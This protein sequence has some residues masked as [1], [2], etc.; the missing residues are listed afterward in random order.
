MKKEYFFILIITLLT[1]SIISEKSL[2][3]ELIFETYDFC[4]I[5]TTFYDKTKFYISFSHPKLISNESSNLQNINITDMILIHQ[6][7]LNMDY[8]ETNISKLVEI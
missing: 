8:W 7:K 6:S 5:I 4:K 2:T 1:K 3:F